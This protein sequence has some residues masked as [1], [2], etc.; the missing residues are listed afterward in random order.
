M[1]IR[2][3]L[4]GILLATFVG[5]AFAAPGDTGDVC[6]GNA[7]TVSLDVC[8]EGSC[9]RLPGETCP[10][11]M[12][13]LGVA[14]DCLTS[15]CTDDAEVCNLPGLGG[16]CTAAGQCPGGTQCV[17][18]NTDVGSCL[19][20]V[21]LG[22]ACLWVSEE[23]DQ[24]G[25]AALECK[26]DMY[27][28]NPMPTLDRVC[29]LKTP[30]SY[31]QAC[32]MNDDCVS[33]ACSKVNPADRT[34]VC[35][36]GLGGSC[37][38]D[39][40][41]MGDNRK[42]KDVDPNDSSAG[43][44]CGLATPATGQ[45]LCALNSDC[46]SDDCRIGMMSSSGSCRAVLGGGCSHDSGCPDGTGKCKP[47]NP[48]DVSAGKVCGLVTGVKH[49]EDC[50]VDDDCL[51]G[52]CS[53]ITAGDLTG[54]CKWE[55]GGYCGADEHCD[56]LG[57]Q[58]KH[59]GS[60]G[61]DTGR[62]GRGVQET[63][64]QSCGMN[65]DC[66]SLMCGKNDPLDLSGICQ[67]PLGGMCTGDEACDGGFIPGMIGMPGNAKC[68][69]V[70]PNDPTAG[71]VCGRTYPM[72]DNQAC[73]VNSDCESEAC[74]KEDP[75]YPTGICK[76]QLGGEC[77]S[78]QDCADP[79][80][81]CKGADG[82][83]NGVNPGKCGLATPVAAGQACAFS[84]DCESSICHKDTSITGTCRSMLGGTCTVDD[85]CAYSQAKCKDI[86]PN[87]V[88]AGKKCG[89]A[90]P[91]PDGES[92]AFD[93]DCESDVC[94]KSNILDSSGACKAQ[95]GGKCNSDDDC[96]DPTTAKCK[97]VDPNDINTTSVCGLANPVAVGQ[98][99]ALDNDCESLICGKGTLADPT[100]I[101]KSPLGG[102][103]TVDEDCGGSNAKCRDVNPD[104]VN[105][106]KV[107]GLAT[108]V[109]DGEP[110]VFGSDCESDA[111]VKVSLVDS[112][113]ICK[114][115]LGGKCNS[116]ADCA[117]SITAKCK[118]VDP[119][120]INTTSVCGLATP[121]P[122]GDSCA[123]DNDCES[124]TCTK[125]DPLTDATG[126][127]R[128]PLGRT[129]DVD[130]DCA[131]SNAEC[132]VVDPNDLNSNKV[133]GIATPAP[134]GNPCALHND[135]ESS[136]CT[137]SNPLTDDTGICRAPL[138]W[139]CDV[140]EDCA[141]PTAVCK[142]LNAIGSNAGK[143]CGLAIEA[144][145]GQA[146]ALDSDCESSTCIKADTITDR[147]GICRAPLGWTCIPNGLTAGKVCGLLIKVDDGESCALNSDC[148]S[149]TC[150]KVNPT[151][152][153]GTCKAP[154][155]WTC[156]VDG[157][158][159]NPAAECKSVDPSDLNAGKVCGLANAVGDGLECAVDSD[160]SGTG[161]TCRV[162]ALEST[163][164]CT[165]PRGAHGQRCA[166]TLPRC[167]GNLL[168]CKSDICVRKAAN[169]VA[170]GGDCAIRS[171]CSEGACMKADPTAAL[172][173]CVKL[174][175][176]SCSGDHCS[177]GLECRAATPRVCL[178]STANTVPLF[179]ACAVNA[180]CRNISPGKAAF[181][182][183]A[184]ATRSLPGQCVQYRALGV[185]CSVGDDCMS[186]VCSG[187]PRTCALSASGSIAAQE[188]TLPAVLVVAGEPH[189][190]TI[191]GGVNVQLTPSIGGDVAVVARG[192]KQATQPAPP[193]TG[194]GLFLTIDTPADATVLE[195]SIN[196]EYLPEH[197]AANNDIPGDQLTWYT[198]DEDEKKWVSCDSESTGWDA[199]TRTVSCKTQHFSD[200]TI[201]TKVSA[202]FAAYMPRLLT[203]VGATALSLSMVF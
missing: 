3:A 140:D 8:F 9:R 166:T 17:I 96:A 1:Q 57:A 90:T 189:T 14:S 138:G 88:S 134:D 168:E 84:N 201:S 103:C 145:D 27:S 20:P 64:G 55:L 195:A 152:L 151:D 47:V 179:G 176:Q 190:V 149:S 102:T 29:G 116:D 24:S 6:D 157:D 144:A 153:S 2:S 196:F 58:C 131:D 26:E 49:G 135:C 117:D 162:D 13:T 125:G 173:K 75:A 40:E 73:A 130:E 25:T 79:N 109:L 33:R 45:D 175:G 38:L 137:K 165:P 93:S 123:L 163:G 148:D 74:V 66:E 139:T 37:T 46:A 72:P 129:C 98:S 126:I 54:I 52:L 82:N 178:Y 56:Y 68:K 91:M 180:D 187:Q 136:T 159:A 50:A 155:G 99:C 184:N 107:C 97:D 170:I 18:F 156:D 161:S 86:N 7:C 182:E 70:D 41:C 167:N 43:K 94:I 127:C 133:C 51:S 110:C 124:S 147:T 34:G 183:K 108:P 53:R 12:G 31:D 62:C 106:G 30:A 10:G 119:N 111:C 23:C 89:I 22:D 78:V 92:C 186:K 16:P 76:A 172:G 69:D 120:D 199:E 150:V 105:V 185:E 42:C 21:Q 141:D 171:D 174:I 121:V 192:E 203:V 160:C 112:T 128:A 142:D 81:V 114:A 115:Q 11:T 202:A 83:P 77:N 71:K 4:A 63:P 35:K 87:D 67:S 61:A 188:I 100:G 158:C 200:W 104:D 113:G 5:S 15:N 154:L 164:V 80:A 181:C 194:V 193:G 101:C 44:K 48:L 28:A 191:P 143:V 132:K 169:K 95:L 59:V 122:D 36:I 197:Q 19:V 146:C 118:D 32:A 198:F 65:D 39:E 60:W 177:T 85:D